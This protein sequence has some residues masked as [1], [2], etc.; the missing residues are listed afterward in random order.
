MNA[1]NYFVEA[2][3]YLGIGIGKVKSE[4]CLDGK[5]ETIENDYYSEDIEGPKPLDYG[6]QVGAGIKINKNISVD[7][8]Y[9]FGLS[10][11]NI[12]RLTNQFGK[13]EGS[14]KNKAIN[15]GVGYSF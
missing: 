10:N 2:G 3:P 13:S 8:R 9:F 4:S 14:F 5:C 7:V 6:L 11:V 15:I 12:L 1:T